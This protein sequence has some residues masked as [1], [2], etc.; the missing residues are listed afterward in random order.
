MLMV[1][2]NHVENDVQ[3]GSNTPQVQLYRCTA[4]AIARHWARN[5]GWNTESSE[6]ECFLV[7][8]FFDND[9]ATLDK[10][11]ISSYV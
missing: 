7:N 8:F 2:K 10:E 1:K 3:Q 4:V 11:Y 5:P 9:V 6:E